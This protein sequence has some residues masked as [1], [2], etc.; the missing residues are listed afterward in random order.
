MTSNN[1]QPTSPQAA[2]AT[3][4]WAAEDRAAVDD[5]DADND[6]WGVEDSSQNDG[7]DELE[8]KLAAME[9]SS[10]SAPSKK[11]AASKKKHKKPPTHSFPC[12]ELHSL[13]EPQA[14]RFEGMDDDDVG[15]SSA[16]SDDEKIRQMLARYMAEEEDEGIL[17]VLR[18][19]A[20]VSSGGVGGD[21]SGRE[22]DERLSAEDR[23]L[24]TYTDRL[25]RSPHQV[26]RYA[27]GGIPMWSM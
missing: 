7:M 5:D 26:L 25:K 18:G 2:S 14:R 22:R 17:A 23:A 1:Q 11:T 9:S 13:Q 8:S 15:V 16:G 27:Y 19:S 24:L 12:Y 3:T 20:D 4:A 10:S 6:D 21:N